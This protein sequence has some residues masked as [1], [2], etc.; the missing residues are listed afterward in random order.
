MD[1]TKAFNI[2]LEFEGGLSDIKNDAGGLTK[3]GISQ[4]AYPGLDIRNLTEE[5]ARLIYEKDY[6]QKAGCDNLKPGLQ[7]IHFD[8]AVNM[9]IATAVKLLQESARI[10]QD[11]IMGPDTIAKSETVLPSEYL[12]YRLARYADIVEKNPLQLVFLKGWTNRVIRLM[13]MSSDIK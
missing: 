13:Q 3:Y 11:G 4:K 10:T 5:Q 7:Y 9:G 8:T 1:I 2:L 12:L 6:W